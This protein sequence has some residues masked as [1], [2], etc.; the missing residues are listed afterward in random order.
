MSETTIPTDTKL[1]RKLNNLKTS[2]IN[3]NDIIEDVLLDCGI[4]TPRLKEECKQ[5]LKEVKEGKY[6]TN[7]EV[8]KELG[9]DPS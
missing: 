2:K 7:E 4:L 1:K 9:I 3:F 5:R 6:V 8:C